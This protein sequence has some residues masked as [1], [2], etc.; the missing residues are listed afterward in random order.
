MHPSSQSINK[1]L[2][3]TLSL[4]PQFRFGLLIIVEQIEAVRLPAEIE[5]G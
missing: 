1:G 5:A 3:H 2:H 4:I